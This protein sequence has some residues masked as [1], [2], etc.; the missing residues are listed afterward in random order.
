[1]ENAKKKIAVAPTPAHTAPIKKKPTKPKGPDKD[2]IILESPPAS[3]EMDPEEF[4]K[5]FEE[6][7]KEKEEA[8]RK[9]KIERSKKK[10]LEKQLLEQAELEKKR[11]Q[12][13]KETQRI[14]EQEKKRVEDEQK[15]REDERKRKIADLEEGEV[16]SDEEEKQK[17]RAKLDQIKSQIALKKIEDLLK[18]PNKLMGG[19]IGEP[20]KSTKIMKFKK[21][22]TLNYVRVEATS[23]SSEDEPDFTELPTLGETSSSSSSSS[24]SGSGS[25][26][27]SSDDELVKLRYKALISKMEMKDKIDSVPLPPVHL[28]RPGQKAPIKQIDT[29]PKSASPTTPERKDRRKQTQHSHVPLKD[30]PPI[31][32]L[33]PV[34]SISPKVNL[35][36][37]NNKQQTGW[38]STNTKAFLETTIKKTRWDTPV[39]PPNIE[40]PKRLPKREN[41]NS[42]D[43]LSLVG[44]NLGNLKTMDKSKFVTKQ[45]EMTDEI[46][47]LSSFVIGPYLVPNNC[48]N[49]I[50]QTAVVRWGFVEKISK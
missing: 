9:A 6:I 34:P 40:A 36:N 10:A 1:M 12:K 20:R 44:I 7:L 4:D 28:K 22:K 2:V 13:K 27:V 49:N 43:E 14:L 21:L 29:R 46:D 19:A 47:E 24:I 25:D 3:P 26:S 37:K 11:E 42:D 50:F 35:G 18:S 31:P 15:R 45:D 30:L 48:Q 41:E 39:E 17:E 16:L 23:D 5:N 33:G 8:L 38:K 32:P